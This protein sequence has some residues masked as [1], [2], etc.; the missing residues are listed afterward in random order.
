MIFGTSVSEFLNKQYV[1]NPCSTNFSMVQVKSHSSTLVSPRNGLKVSAQ[2]SN[3]SGSA[4]VSRLPLAL[5]TRPFLEEQL[6]YLK[7]LHFFV[8]LHE[9]YT[10]II[11]DYCSVPSSIAN[12]KRLADLKQKM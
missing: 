12:L 5:F 2:I 9:E 4:G 1:S 10:S 8:I 11:G 6:Q 7:H 3:Y